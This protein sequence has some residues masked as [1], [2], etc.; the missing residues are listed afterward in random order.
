MFEHLSPYLAQILDYICTTTGVSLSQDTRDSYRRQHEAVGTSHRSHVCT[1]SPPFSMH[2]NYHLFLLC[3]G[4]LL[5]ITVGFE[6]SLVDIVEV[7]VVRLD[8][9]SAVDYARGE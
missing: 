1:L 7:D 6:F 4:D 2:T 8:F 3:N 9:M 5:I